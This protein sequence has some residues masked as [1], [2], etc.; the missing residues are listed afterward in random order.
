M[1]RYCRDYFS[2]ITVLNFQ[3]K[4]DPQ[5]PSRDQIKRDPQDPSKEWV[6]PERILNTLNVILNRLDP[7]Y[8]TGPREYQPK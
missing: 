2:S 3:T 8:S 1:F 7:I 5:D 6:T 4:R